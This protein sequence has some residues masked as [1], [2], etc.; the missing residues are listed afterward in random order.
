MPQSKVNPGLALLLIALTGAGCSSTPGD[1]IPGDLFPGASFPGASISSSPLMVLQQ[2]GGAHFRTLVHEGWWYQTQRD[3]LLVVNPATFEIKHEVAFAPPG[4]FGGA[5]DMVILDH[6]LFVVL[7]DDGI[8]HLDLT[9]PS[10]PRVIDFTDARTLGILPRR[11]SVVEN[12]LYVSGKGGVVRFADGTRIFV[13]L[14][15]VMHVVKAEGGLVTCIGRRVHRVSDRAFV[16]S[17]STLQTLPASFGLSG[18]LV[19]VRHVEGGSQVGLMTPDIREVSTK[20]STVMVEG[21][22]SRIRFHSGLIW[23]VS[24]RSLRAYRIEGM[25]L[26]LVHRFDGEGFRDVGLLEDNRLA[27]AGTFG[28]GILRILDDAG[29]PGG[30][31]IRMHVEPGQLIQ[32]E[33]DGRRILA[34]DGGAGDSFWLYDMA[35]NQVRVTDRRPNA[36]HETNRVALTLD[37]RAV[38][39][40]SSRTITLTL[41]G[42]E[43]TYLEPDRSLIRCVVSVGG[44]FWLGHDRGI[45]VLD[46][47]RADDPVI[48]RL[49]LPGP[50]GWIFPQL[51]GNGAAYVSEFGGF[52]VVEFNASF[53]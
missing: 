11:L 50:V 16:G 20:T 44:Y 15:D 36:S 52:G 41:S 2:A 23:I 28:R 12:R 8:A 34:G 39:D 10:R 45:T 48:G 22:V 21:R 46:P 53:E 31:M 30:A 27:V 7:Q 25:K 37:A 1:L 40:E 47:H 5:V 32:A 24:D 35:D 18:H 38:I 4:K 33:S 29:G 3:R 6:N 19:F 9:Q 13:D 26:A 43:R 51:S 42:G 14:G 49:R 17:A